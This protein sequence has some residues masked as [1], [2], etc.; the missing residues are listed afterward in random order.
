MS[1]PQ[2]DM[3]RRIVVTL[4]IADDRHLEILATGAFLNLLEWLQHE[5]IESAWASLEI[6]GTLA[7]W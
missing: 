5:G 2:H 6:T 7:D 1:P 4:D 3:L